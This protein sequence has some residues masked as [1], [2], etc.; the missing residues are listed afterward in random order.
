M[1]FQT[2]TSFPATMHCLRPWI[3]RVV[4]VCLVLAMNPEGIRAASTWNPSLLVNTEAFQVIDDDD[5]N[6]DVQLR[7]G[8]TVNEELIYDKTNKRF[9]FTRSLFVS[10]N[11]VFT[12]SLL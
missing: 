1:R 2:P 12:G 10:G 9:K 5:S 6:S 11:G 3:A 8:D 7:F 4:I